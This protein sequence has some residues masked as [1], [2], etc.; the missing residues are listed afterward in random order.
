VI[1]NGG[2]LKWLV[3][4]LEGAGIE[5]MICGSLGSTFHGEQRATNDVDV[6]IA[7]TEEQLRRLLES[8]P[9]DVY[10]SP[11]A[12]WDAFR[13]RSMFNI[14]DTASG[15]KADLTFR[16]NRPFSLEEFQRRRRVGLLGTEVQIVSPEDSILSKLEWAKSGESQRQFRDALGVALVQC[17]TLDWEYLRKWAVELSV[18]DLL[19][20]LVGESQ[21]TRPPDSALGT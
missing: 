2:F 5:Y 6:V 12:A 15:C 1:S 21:G 17:E 14:I 8:L 4:A 13:R 9:A 16:K 11:A 10:V 7:A 20:K 18:A 19:E 3:Q